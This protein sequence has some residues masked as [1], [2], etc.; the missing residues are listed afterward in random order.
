MES[1]TTRV[2][3]H[4]VVIGGSMAGLL[5][6]R[7]LADHFDRVTLMERDHYPVTG[8]NRRGVPQGKHTHGL[9]ASGRQIVEGLFPGIS[10]SLMDGGAVACDVCRDGIWFHEGGC[11]S[12]FLGDLEGLVMSRPFFEWQV[13]ER[14]RRLGNVMIAEGCSV[15]GLLMDDE[16]RRVVGVRTDS[17]TVPADLVVDASGRGSPSPRWLAE[18]GYPKPPEERVEV[19]L[20]YTTRWFRRRADGASPPIVVIPPTAQGKRGGV[21]LAQEGD[22][23]T[24]TLIGHFGHR[25]PDDRDGFIEYS[26][27]LPGPFIYDVIREA[28]PLGEASSARFPAS[29]RFRYERVPRFPEGYL[30]AGDAICSFNPI[31][32]QGMTVAAF[33]AVEL[34]KALEQGEQ[35]LAKRF[36]AQAAKVID[37]PWSI[38]VGNDL[39]MPET[40]GPRTMGV[41]IINWYVSKLHRAAHHDPVAAMAFHKVGNLLAP[42]P[43]IMRPAI[44]IRVL[45]GNLF[46]PGVRE[47]P[48]VGAD[49]ARF[50]AGN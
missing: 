50:A 17:G 44:A 14:V 38:A 48:D 16:R 40:T 8:A 37:I 25:A 11:L 43:S 36:F 23:W 21:M 35:N 39:R 24:V 33:Q 9:L 19:A 15:D 10:R 42:P 26:R 32:G 45:K 12:R 7:V 34:K 3:N 28:E 22:R 31:Y 47:R 29:V 6:T 27:T 41:R 30:V 4:A 2:R 18:F 1:K 49:Q 5:A 46:G 20:A 13:R